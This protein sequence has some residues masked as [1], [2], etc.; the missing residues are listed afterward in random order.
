[1]KC[2]VALIVLFGVGSL[3]VDSA[4][5]EG[6][7]TLPLGNVSAPARCDG[8]LSADLSEVPDAPTQVTDAALVVA[9]DGKTDTPAHCEIQGYVAPRVGFA[10]WLP[11]DRWNGKLLELG[12]GGSCGSTKQVVGCSDPVRRGTRSRTRA[13]P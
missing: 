10:L 9:K 7:S 8:L 3:Y 11:A 2:L 5:G 1:M 6:A 4:V 12:C 13:A